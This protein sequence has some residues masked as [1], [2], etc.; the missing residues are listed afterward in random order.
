MDK[1]KTVIKAFNIDFNW[2]EGKAAPPGL[3]TGAVPEEHIKWYVDL[4]VNTFW[5]FCTTY[6]GYAWYPSKIA[7]V[8]P[9]L[10]GDFM[11]KCTELGKKNGLQVYAYMCFGA[12]PWWEEQ[13]PERVRPEKDNY[14]KVVFD[15]YMSTIFAEYWKRL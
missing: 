15:D 8:N 4:G 10:K 11:N 6:N 5:T 1:N 3:F 14:I 13:N 9:G 2:F 12:N 7:P